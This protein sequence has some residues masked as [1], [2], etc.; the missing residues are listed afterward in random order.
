MYREVFYFNLVVVISSIVSTCYSFTYFFSILFLSLISDEVKQN[1]DDTIEKWADFERD[2]ERHTKWCR[3]METTFKDSSACSTLV[4]KQ[5]KVDLISEKRDDIVKYEKEIDKFVDLGHVLLRISSVERLK[6]L[7]TQLSNRYQ[8]L[9]VLSKESIGKWCSISADHKAY[10]TKLS[11]YGSWLDNIKTQLVEVSR[12][13]DYAERQNLL[14]HLISERDQATHRLTSITSLGERLYPYTATQG[15]EKVRQDL[16][17][18]R[19]QWDTIELGISE[20][21]R[22][23]DAQV[24]QSTALHDSVSS[25]RNWLENIEK[26]KPAEPSNWLSVQEIRSKLLKQKVMRDIFKCHVFLFMKF[27]NV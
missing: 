18:L 6:P 20:Q 13:Q 16:K 22:A 4:E 24:Q 9:H 25:A 12:E 3:D 7:V 27:M 5:K 10:E 21:Q 26:M 23:Q 19:D 2:N 15:R 14:S 11:E 17:L 1:L 8:C